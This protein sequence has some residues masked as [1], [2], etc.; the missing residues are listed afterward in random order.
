MQ[1][2][3]R[4]GTPGRFSNSK[5]PFFTVRNPYFP[6]GASS[7]R[8]KSAMEPFSTAGVYGSALHS[9]P[10][11]MTIFADSSGGTNVPME[12]ATI[13]QTWFCEWNSILRTARSS[14]GIRLTYSPTSASLF[15]PFH[16]T[17]AF[18]RFRGAQ[19]FSV[20]LENGTLGGSMEGSGVIGERSVVI[21]SE[22]SEGEILHYTDQYFNEYEVVL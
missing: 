16:P 17:C 4:T 5:C 7:S 2:Q 11:R 19:K 14:R 18:G 8:E 15:R 3:N 6:A 9:F 1:P 22:A 10:S 21:G 20:S 13:I 12:A